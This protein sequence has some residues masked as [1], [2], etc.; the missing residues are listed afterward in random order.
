MR[1]P[2]PRSH[3]LDVTAPH[4]AAGSPP[5]EQRNA[6]LRVLLGVDAGAEIRGCGVPITVGRG[7]RSD[8]RLS[9]NTV[10]RNHF[11]LE[12]RGGHWVIRDGTSCNG[13]YLN[14]RRI[15]GATVLGR[16]DIIRAG[17]SSL[18]LFEGS[19][20]QDADADNRLSLDGS[21]V[22]AELEAVSA[23]AEEVPTRD[24][25]SGCAIRALLGELRPD[26]P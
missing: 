13:T 26:E 6:R 7:G 9:D 10:S 4:Q 16:G 3:Y 22:S 14:G 11:T 18:R 23:R 19:G 17:K 1:A 5:V 12:Y 24:D 2:Q 15:E 20:R 25:S 8:L 21:L